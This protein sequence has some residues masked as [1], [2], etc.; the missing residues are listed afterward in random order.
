MRA[1]VGW[2][3]VIRVRRNS[4]IVLRRMETVKWISPDGNRI[5]V[6]L[7]GTGHDAG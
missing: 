5:R 6:A 1:R 7:Y 3:D 4:V 2:M